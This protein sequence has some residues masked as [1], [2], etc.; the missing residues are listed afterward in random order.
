M[1]VYLLENGRKTICTIT[2]KDAS[3]VVLK[4]SCP[5]CGDAV[6][7]LQGTGKRP[8]SDDQ[9]WEADAVAACCHKH[10]GTLR[11]ETSTMF[12]V[13]EDEVVLNGRCRVY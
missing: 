8:S 10:V 4:G 1:K 7:K 12:G 6:C 5:Q 11:V 3:H 2:Y 9:A 13:R